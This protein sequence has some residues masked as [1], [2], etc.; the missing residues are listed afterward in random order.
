VPRPQH[1]VSN[2]FVC[3]LSTLST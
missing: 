2:F 1:N 3:L